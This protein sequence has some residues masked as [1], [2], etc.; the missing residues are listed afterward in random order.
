[1]FSLFI[2]PSFFIRGTLLCLPKLWLIIVWL[3]LKFWQ[4]P[5]L[6]FK[7]SS[8]FFQ[9]IFR[10]LSS[11]IDLPLFFSRQLIWYS[12]PAI[13]IFPIYCTHSS[14][15]WIF[16][17]FQWYPVSNASFVRSQHP[18]AYAKTF[19]CFFTVYA[20]ILT[21]ILFPFSYFIVIA[22]SIY[23]F[24]RYFECLLFTHLCR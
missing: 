7:L 1:M 21:M 12:L 20:A 24:I 23:S 13:L 2:P 18:P 10:F 9:Y 4:Y 5:V 3:F 6:L 15:F 22:F 14:A 16:P 17:S 19:R 8:L 11:F